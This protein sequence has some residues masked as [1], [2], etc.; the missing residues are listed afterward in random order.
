MK[1]NLDRSKTLRVDESLDALRL[2]SSAGRKDTSALLEASRRDGNSLSFD[3]IN[4]VDK[5][6]RGY[7]T[8][9]CVAQLLRPVLVGLIEHTILHVSIHNCEVG[10]RY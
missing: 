10:K 1:K 6:S 9:D 7:L 8:L 3:S 2:F 4:S 5:R